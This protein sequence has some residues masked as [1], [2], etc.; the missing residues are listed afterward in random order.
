MSDQLISVTR[1]PSTRRLGWQIGAATAS[2]LLLNTGRR[3]PYPFAPALSRGLDVPLTAI[4]SLIAINLATGLL[5]PLFGPLSDRWGYRVM[6]LLSLGMFALGML[7]GGLLPFYLVIMAALFLAG[8][9]KSIFD[10]ALQAYLGKI[11]PYERRGLVIGLVEFGWSGSSLIGIP[12]IALLIERMGWQSPFLILGGLTLLAAVALGILI[13]AEGRQPITSTTTLNFRAVWREVRGNR[14]ALGVL[15]FA[16]LIGLANDNLFVVYGAWLEGS[17][18]LSIVALGAASSVI[19]IAEM[20]GEGLTASVADRLGLKR[21]IIA[22]LALSSLSYLLLPLFGHTLPLALAG[23]FVVFLSFEFAIVTTIS[24]A[25]EVLP[26]ARAT[27]MASMMAT[28]SVGRV[29]GALAG[30]SIWLAGGL[31]AISLVSTL[32][33]ALSLGCLWWGLKHWRQG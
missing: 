14:A 7:A 24:L 21:S 19:G 20:I 8:L 18:A 31:T 22:G 29:I 15:G 10:P 28:M 1:P 6:M 13:P 11:V 26:A 32:A 3:F 23:L 4:T 17:F 9:S 30:G 27:M 33:T 5:S 25:T 2:R 16:F 12:L